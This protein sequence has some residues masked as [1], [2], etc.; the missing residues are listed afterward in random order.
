MIH[1]T[2]HA[3]SPGGRRHLSTAAAAVVASVLFIAGC[4]SD[5]GSAGSPTTGASDSGAASTAV[6][7]TE[8]TSTGD[9]FA[10]PDDRVAKVT[11]AGLTIAE[12]RYSEQPDG[13]PWPTEEWPTGDL[14]DKVD[15]GTIDDIVETAF[16]EDD[17]GD[18]IDA[19]L[20]VQGGELVLEEY[21]GWD[22]DAAHN[23]W[24]MAKSINSALVGILVGEGRL[25]IWQPV[26]APEWDDPDD[27]R[28]E[29]TLDQLLR[30]SSG[31]EWEESYTDPDAD[32]ITT[33]GSDVDR[34]HYTADKPLAHEPDTF[35]YYSTGTSNLIARSVAQQVGYGD[36]LTGWADD[37]LFAPLGITS[38][39]HNLD[40]EGLI[41]GGSFID[42][43]PQDFARFGLLYARDGVWDGT[44]ILPEGWVDY[45]RM[46]TFTMADGRYA[47][48]WWLDP[49]RP[50]LFYASG[51]NGQ[52]INVVPGKDL[53]I[54]V[55]STA[56]G[57]RDNQVR[58]DLFDAFGV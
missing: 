4:S 16:A 25:D 28:A 3:G 33:L 15:S 10:L 11:E 55:L 44:R 42:M 23:S 12:P 19:I 27:P 38:V 32:V 40:S 18:T 14:P 35:W 48:Q 47:A 54:V 5:T 17:S 49:K 9:G 53:V 45:S 24:S 36:Q 6:G 56:P 29:I 8:P 7:P 57:G 50:D 43:T 21:N 22:P 52:S 41:S 58:N 31:L 46:P 39:R 1:R 26:D 13:V 34:A 20:A 51:F 2:S 37:A 30:M